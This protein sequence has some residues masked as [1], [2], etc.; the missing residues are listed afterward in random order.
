MNGKR[1]ETDA[2]VR[3]GKKFD[4]AT[5]RDSEE[6]PYKVCIAIC[7][8]NR[9]AWLDTCLGSL[10]HQPHLDKIEVLVVNNASSDHTSAIVQRHAVSFPCCREVFEPRPGIG[11]ARNRALRE[12]ELSWQ[13]H[14]DDDAIV[15]EHYIEVLLQ[16]I[17]AAEFDCVGGV[18]EAW[19]PEGKVPWFRDGFGSNASVMRQP[20]ALPADRFA[21][22]GIM[23]LRREVVL[24]VGGFDDRLGPRGRI[25]SYGEETRMQVSLR[26]HGFSIGFAPDWRVKH[27]VSMEKQTVGWQLRSSWVLG[28]DSWAGLGRQPGM[29]LLVKLVWRLFR[30]PIVGLFFELWRHDQPFSWQTLCLSFLK[31]LIMTLSELSEG[32][33]LKLSGVAQP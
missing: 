13:A 18:Y 4:T 26:E 28:R 22:A 16:L 27:R 25:L 9:A 23:L 24:K 1:H 21:S 7:T 29:W 3:L 33:R 10:A 19:Y 17:K 6:T 8:H 12:T 31:P 30:R 2:V 11:H 14:L 20:G 32:L 15:C 5:G